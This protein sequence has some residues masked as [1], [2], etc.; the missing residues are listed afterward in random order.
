VYS[1]TGLPVPWRS[2]TCFAADRALRGVWYAWSRERSP[3]YRT[4]LNQVFAAGV[5]ALL[6]FLLA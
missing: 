1:S 6:Y 5:V 3:L 4:V 2:I